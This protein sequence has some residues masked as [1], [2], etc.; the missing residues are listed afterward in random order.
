[1]NKNKLVWGLALIAFGIIWLLNIAGVLSI[2]IWT[3]FFRLW[4][5]I[6]IA[7][8]LSI[9]FNRKP[10]V[11]A[12]IWIIFFAVLIIYSIFGAGDK[13]DYSLD[14]FTRSVTMEQGTKEAHAR[15]EA[16]GASVNI[17]GIGEELFYAD[18]YDKDIRFDIKGGK[19][20]EIHVYSGLKSR[21][22]SD[23]G[24]KYKWD[25][26]LSENVEW[27][28]DFDAG[29]V[30]GDFDLRSI[31]VRKLTID[32]GASALDLRLSDLLEYSEVEIRAGVSSISI[33]VPEDTGI[34]LRYQGALVAKNLTEQGFEKEGDH[35]YS[36]DYEDAEK[37][38]DILIEM[39]VG[40]LDFSFK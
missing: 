16:G 8:G 4:P 28:I 14:N 18:I 10:V 17:R 1:M 23:L 6:F 34:K 13:T 19:T 37:K 12:L 20:P 32:I 2:S 3:S 29:A 24:D 38:I 35:Y 25:I 11:K 36:K 21:N 26:D 22:I 30:K 5:M 31:P 39:G 7:I 27:T 15:L 9:I 40:N 33:S